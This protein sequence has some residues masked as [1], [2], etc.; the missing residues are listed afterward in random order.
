MRKEPVVKKSP[1][2]KIA[3][4]YCGFTII[5]IIIVIVIIG[6]LASVAMPSYN[7]S[8]ERTKSAEGI[9]VLMAIRDAQEIYFFENGSYYTGNDINGNLDVTINA[10]DNFNMP[11]APNP[12]VG[13]VQIQR[14]GGAYTFTIDNN[15]TIT[16]AGGG[17]IC[18]QI[19]Y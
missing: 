14:I 11:T 19:G 15:G 7:S 2:I 3:G 18:S 9:Q 10:L 13:V 16:C 1:V 12:A 6:V 4:H 17:N 5:E 8:V